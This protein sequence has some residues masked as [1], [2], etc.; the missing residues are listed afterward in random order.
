MKQVLR[1]IHK[2]EKLYSQAGT[3]DLSKQ[4]LL[5]LALLETAGWLENSFDILYLSCAKNENTRFSIE[6]YIAKIYS[7]DW[8]CLRIGLIFGLGVQSVY[9]LEC[10]AGEE[11]IHKMKSIVGNLKRYRDE[12]AHDYIHTTKHFISFH[13]LKKQIYFLYKGMCYI[14]QH[15]RK[16]HS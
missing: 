16:I 11:N 5:K 12:L 6:Q 1:H 7:F 10:A 14:Q 2:C 4:L 15:I 13:N 3:D 8:T 9:E